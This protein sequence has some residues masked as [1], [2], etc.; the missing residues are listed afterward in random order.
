[1]AFAIEASTNLTQWVPLK[2]NVTTSGYFDY[3]DQGAAGF[4]HRFYRGRWVP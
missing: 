3:V 1:M 2:T 4:L